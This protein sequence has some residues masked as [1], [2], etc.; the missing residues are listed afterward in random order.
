[1]VLVVLILT[2]IGVIVMLSASAGISL[3]KTGSP[4]VLWI[5]HL[6]R[7][8][9]GLIFL[10]LFWRIDYHYLRILSRPLIVLVLVLLSLLLI[11]RWGSSAARWLNVLGISFQPSELAK[12]ALI[13]YLADALVRKRENLVELSGTM[14]FVVIIALIA[15]LVALQP[16][17]SMAAMVVILGGTM[18][19]LGG[20]RLR[21][22]LAAAV[23]TVPPLLVY[24]YSAP[25]RRARLFSFFNPLSDIQGDGYQ[26]WQS[27]IA[28]GRGGLFGV[29]PGN[30]RQKFHFLP[31]PYKDFIFSILGEE[32]GLIGTLLVVTLF[33]IIF[34]RGMRIA[35][36]APDDFGRLLAAGIVFSLS[37]NALIN[38]G[39][40]AGVLPT[41]GLPLP[42]LS[43]GGT[44]M[45]LFLASIGVLINISRHALSPEERGG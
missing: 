38:I 14:P 31:E 44:S 22:L 11:M 24:M 10:L 3:D 40:A 9:V 12:L 32:W 7:V 20:V 19:F 17:F 13:L 6:K 36:L 43:F 35:R 45:V 30:G 26:R 25:Y 37:Y 4:S 16:N 42:Y 1:M 8:A 5:S 21:Y 41:T 2:A 27:L 34:W 15:G 39:V 33:I 18:L 29:G 23:V 28:L